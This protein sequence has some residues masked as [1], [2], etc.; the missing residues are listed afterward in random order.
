[1]LAVKISIKIR[2]IIKTKTSGCLHF[3]SA[4]YGSLFLQHSAR[5]ECQASFRRTNNMQNIRISSKLRQHPGDTVYKLQ[6][7]RSFQIFIE[8]LSL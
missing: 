5:E 6:K 3:Y 7:V 1:M 2:I 8:S 4:L